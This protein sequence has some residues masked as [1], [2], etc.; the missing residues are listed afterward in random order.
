VVFKRNSGEWG[1]K[2]IG[3]IKVSKNDLCNV[4]YFR[5]NREIKTSVYTVC[6]PVYEYIMVKTQ[7]NFK[8]IEVRVENEIDL[9]T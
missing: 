1:E 6:L 9:R 5:Y 3:L 8:K 2:E 4:T 7:V